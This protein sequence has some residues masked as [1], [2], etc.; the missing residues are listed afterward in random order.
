LRLDTTNALRLGTT[1]A[2]RLDTRAGA[3]MIRAGAT[4]NT[5]D[6]ADDAKDD[7]KDGAKD[8]AARR[9]REAGFGRRGREAGLARLGRKL[10]GGWFLLLLPML[11]LL[12]AFELREARGPHWL[13]ENLDPTYMYLLNSL[14]VA[15]L[16]RPFLYQHPGAPVSI[17]GGLVIRLSHPLTGERELA[18]RV[19]SDPER[20][21]IRISNVFVA[22]YALAL[23]LAGFCALAATGR[24]WVA[25]LY[26]AAPFVSATTVEGLTGVRPE[27]LLSALALL[28]GATALLALRYDVR[29]HARRYALAFGVL[30]G[31]GVACKLNFAPLALLPLVLLPGVRAR[32]EYVAAAFVSFVFFTAPIIAPYHLRGALDYFGG[33]LTHTGRYGSGPAGFI[34]PRRYVEGAL[35]LVAADWP[36][37]A[38]VAAGLVLLLRARVR[39]RRGG[40]GGARVAADPALPD[41]RVVAR[42]VLLAAVAAELAQFLLVAKHPGARYLVPSLGLAGLNLALLAEVLRPRRPV[43]RAARYALAA[44][45][46]ALAFAQAWRLSAQRAQ[47]AE[48]AREQLATHALAERERRH[49]RVVTYYSAS[50]VHY[51]LR[52]G[53][54]FSNN[55]YGHVLEELYPGQLFWNPW[56]RQ[57]STFRTRLDAGQFRAAAGDSFVLHGYSLRDSDFLRDLPP[58][59][60]PEGLI[61]EEL[62][63]G[64]I[65]RPDHFDGEALFRARFVNAP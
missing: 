35:S 1:N 45:A 56:I 21:L 26:Q 41:A 18:R 64:R 15:N 65:D 19:L 42:R 36:F 38:L 53:S 44:A 4:E 58:N 20:Y 63:R 54:E 24:A 12:A 52:L 32:V 29:A 8:G 16:H 17:A 47:F 22:C 43:P 60:M 7:A 37:F 40:A 46:L 30:V 3:S 14:N 11:V 6:D 10:A 27:P 48:S 51:A 59:F 57:F 33:I 13:S 5:M 25:L 61:L 9:G 31:L 23:L 62:H 34:D 2:L 50:S 39:G 28:L 49:A 55:F